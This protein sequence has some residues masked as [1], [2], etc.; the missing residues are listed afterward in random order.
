[1]FAGCLQPE[2]E[3][4][5]KLKSSSSKRLHIVPLDVGLDSSME[6]AHDYVKKNL[7]KNGELSSKG[8]LKKKFIHLVIGKCEFY[9]NV[10]I[11]VS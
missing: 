1:M 11:L 2:G 3:G 4:A 8:L 6:A 5:K 9:T 10:F 7:P